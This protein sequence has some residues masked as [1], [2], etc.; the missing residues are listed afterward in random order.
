MNVGEIDKI[1]YAIQAEKDWVQILKILAADAG[2]LSLHSQFYH[3]YHWRRV[4]WARL[5]PLGSGHIGFAVPSISLL[6]EHRC[7]P[8]GY[9]RFFG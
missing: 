8:R 1:L 5:W 7:E 6:W 3:P 9:S 2:I 4:W